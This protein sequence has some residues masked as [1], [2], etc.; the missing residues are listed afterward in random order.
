MV[1]P[2]GRLGGPPCDD[3]DAER[4]GGQEDPRASAPPVIR[5]AALTVEERREVSERLLIAGLREQELAETLAAERAQLAAILASIG[6]AVLVVDHAGTAVLTNAAFEEMLGGAGMAPQDAYGAALPT[7]MWPRQ[8]IA[9]GETFSMQF[10]LTAAD[11]TQR[12]FEANGRP[13]LGALPARGVVVIRD[14]TAVSRQRRLQDNFVALASHELRTPLTLVLGRLQLLLLRLPPQPD[15]GETRGHATVALRH[16]QRL[17]DL[18]DD[19]MD[20]TRLETGKLSLTLG[21]VDLAPLVTRAVETAQSLATDQT[22][23]ATVAA[24]PVVVTG[25]A[26]RLEQV[27]LNLLTNAI[28]YAPGPARIEARLRRVGDEAAVIEVQDE[29]PG[30]AEGDQARLFNR[31]S[32]V[33]GFEHAAQGG[34]GLGLYL[35]CELITAHGGTIVV[36]STWG[37]GTIFTV[38]LPLRAGDPPD[39]TQKHREER[40]E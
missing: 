28:K 4:R 3:H 36:H 30:I 15:H 12:W 1:E 25:D 5:S 11:G 18:V 23:H 26:G 38:R 14:I 27:M 6:D 13:I 34:L 39:R 33:E 29:G 21:P 24:A 35:C 2:E 20:M 8:R 40:A 9:R 32:Q 7:V 10:A 16:A 17:A 31:F 19:L 22:I 37:K